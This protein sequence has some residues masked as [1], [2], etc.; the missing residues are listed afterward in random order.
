MSLHRFQD[1][2]LQ[3][4]HTPFLSF[5]STIIIITQEQ[6]PQNALIPDHTLFRVLKKGINFFSI[7]N[8]GISQLANSHLFNNRE[9]LAFGSLNFKIILLPIPESFFIKFSTKRWKN[10]FSHKFQAH[11]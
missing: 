8:S 5:Q 3:H 6:S 9:V 1:F 4:I 2:S 11:H 7:K 10:D